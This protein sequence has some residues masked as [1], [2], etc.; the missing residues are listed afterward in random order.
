MTYY[1]DY[2]A[3]S[4]IRPQQV[5]DA[6]S[7]FLTG[8]GATPGRG[9]HSRALAA[10]RMALHC[11]QQVARLLGVSGD[12][13]RIAFMPNATYGLNAALAGSLRAGDTVVISEYDHNSVRR[14]VHA[15]ERS[16]GVV[17]R[18]ISG[19]PDGAVDLT[20]VER[21]LEGA[22]LLVVNEV[23][24]VLGTKMPLAQLADLAHEAGALVLV[25]A[26]QSVGH[27][28]VSHGADGADMV[29]FTGHKGMLGP[30]GT[31]GLW[32]REGVDIEPTVLG[33]TGGV[34]SQ[35]V[36]MPASMPDRLEAGSVNGPGLA[37][38]LAGCRFLDERGVASIHEEIGALKTQLR[39]GLSEISRVRVLSP[40]AP[41]GAG[42]V[43]ITT[44][45]M[46]ASTLASRLDTEWGVMGRAGLHCAPEIHQIIGTAA[47]GAFRL[48][49]G[50]ASTVEDVHR[51]IEGVHAL[52]KSAS[53][54]VS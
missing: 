18:S 17:V 34:H 28:P 3:T 24:N 12:P 39:D 21:L 36:S 11:R 31:G 23:S 13:G 6:V 14:P 46:D 50:W 19:S 51:A 37:G 48:S 1:L 5:V 9:G 4:A 45:A 10:G 32:A 43:T 27:V 41:D 40:E 25:D 47:S 54:P 2:A 7:D 26:A 8:C 53:V 15:L 44:A 42:I 52:A 33:G 38:L 30:Q 35:A 20:E 29:A 49:L 22:T 16:R